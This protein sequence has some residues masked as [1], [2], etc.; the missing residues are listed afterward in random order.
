MNAASRVSGLS[1]MKKLQEWL[2]GLSIAVALWAFLYK[3]SEIPA[4]SLHAY[5]FQIL[6]APIVALVLFAV[7]NIFF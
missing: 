1:R 5:K 4:S 6:I 7:S 3:Q 2:L